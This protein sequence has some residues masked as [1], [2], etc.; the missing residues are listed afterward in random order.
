MGAGNATAAAKR[1]TVTAIVPSWITDIIASTECCVTQPRRVVIVWSPWVCFTFTFTLLQIRRW[2]QNCTMSASPSSVR[3]AF[4]RDGYVVLRGVIPES[5][6]LPIE[7]MYTRLVDEKAEDWHRRGLVR[8]LGTGLPFNSRL[9]VLAAQLPEDKLSEVAQGLDI[10]ESL[11]PELHALTLDAGLLD[12]VQGLIGPEITLSPIQH[13]RP[14]VGAGD[15]DQLHLWH[16]DMTVTVPEADGVE[17]IT[18]WLPLVDVAKETGCMQFA[19][20]GHTLPELVNGHHLTPRPYEEAGGRTLPVIDTPMRR[21]DVVLFGGMTPHRG[22]HIHALDFVRWSVDVRFQRTGT[23]SGRPQ[24]PSFVVRS[25]TEPAKVDRSH[26]KWAARW[27]R[28]LKTS[29]TFAHRTSGP[30]AATAGNNN[31][32]APESSTSKL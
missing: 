6:M 23:P 12:A 30:I 25:A 32:S 3:T 1:H 24:W 17:M 28:A 26:S 11:V 13:I 16:C 22:Q 7:Q 18:A 15:R 5:T 14:H 31:N 19:R 10:Y 2:C 29:P 27:R 20:G 9:A 8:D 21:G 4:D